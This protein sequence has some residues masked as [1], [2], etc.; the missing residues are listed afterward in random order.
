MP[1][2]APAVYRKFG[3]VPTPPSLRPSSRAGTALARV[4]PKGLRASAPLQGWP[5]RGRLKQV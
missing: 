1:P 4:C 3:G 5:R 2:P